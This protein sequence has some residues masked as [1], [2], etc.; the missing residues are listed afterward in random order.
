MLVLKITML[1]GRSEEKKAELIQRLTQSAAQH[2][3]EP[4]E[5]IR[6]LIYEIPPTDWGAG[7]ITIA[8]RHRRS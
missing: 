5:S 7:G 1:E 4:A 6:I 2:L 8:E 3:N